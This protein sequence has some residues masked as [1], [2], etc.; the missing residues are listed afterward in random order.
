MSKHEFMIICEGF[1][2]VKSNIFKLN[3]PIFRHDGDLWCDY[4]DN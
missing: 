2:K 3:G 4:L 1:R